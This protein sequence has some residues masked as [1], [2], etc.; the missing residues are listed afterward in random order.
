MPA[1]TLHVALVSNHPSVTPRE[2]ARVASAIS[3]QVTRDLAP[4]W[5][6]SATVDPFHS[7]D[8]VPHTH[9]PVIVEADIDTPGAAGVH[10]NEQDGSP[11]A[12]VAYSPDWSLT[13]SH[14]TLEMLVDPSGSRLFPCTLDGQPVK[15]LAEVC[16]PSEDDAYAYSING[17]KVSDFYYPSYLD[18]QGDLVC[19]KNSPLTPL[20]VLPGGYLSYVDASGTW[21]QITWFDGD[22]PTI[23]TLGRLVKTGSWRSVIDKHV[24]A[25]RAGIALP[26]VLASHT[27]TS[28]KAQIARLKAR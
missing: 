18:P 15:V 2:L 7:L 12:L 25:R 3:V 24:N 27:D 14:E 5:G 22:T 10:E 11:F 6:I 4:A 21:H 1:P 9:M 17:V 20:G 23:T 19:A 28:L 26:P 13:A 16:D 8:D